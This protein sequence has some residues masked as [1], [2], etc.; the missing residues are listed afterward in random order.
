VTHG[1]EKRLGNSG[2]QLPA[3]E[4][5]RGE[6]SDGLPCSPQGGAL[7]VA[8]GEQR[9]ARWRIDGGPRARDSGGKSEREREGHE[10]EREVARA[11]RGSTPFI[12]RGR[13][14]KGWQ[15]RG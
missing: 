1:G 6:R 2:E 3:R 14:R 10:R 12:G 11:R 4:V 7:A 8:C 13:E 5:E 15:E 9:A